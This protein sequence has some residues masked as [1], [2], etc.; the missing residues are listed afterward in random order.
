MATR[1]SFW[2]SIPSSTKITRVQLISYRLFN[3]TDTLKIGIKKGNHVY[4][5]NLS[6]KKTLSRFFSSSQN[7]S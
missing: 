7:V 6:K 5:A 1:T 4:Y 2:Q 3:K